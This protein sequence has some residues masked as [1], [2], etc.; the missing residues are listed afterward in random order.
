[1]RSA[2][3][4]SLSIIL[5]LSS[6]SA[7]ALTLFLARSALWRGEVS[8]APWRR[9]TTISAAAARRDSPLAYGSMLGEE[10]WRRRENNLWWR[11]GEMSEI[12]LYRRRYL[13]AKNGVGVGVAS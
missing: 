11:G 6:A 13:L 9:A 3:G 2:Y 12:A 10:R 4:G 8:R 5:W 7:Y 1:V